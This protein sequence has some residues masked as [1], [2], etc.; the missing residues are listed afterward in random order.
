MTE[1]NASDK[2]ARLLQRIQSGDQA[3][4]EQLVAALYDD[5]RRIA[6]TH[7]RAERQGHTLQPTAL[8]HEAYVRV[9]ARDPSFADRTHFVATMA[10]A[11]RRILVDYARSRNG[12]RRGGRHRVQLGSEEQLSLEAAD[13]S[14]LLILDSA[15]DRL[16]LEKEE[17]ARFVEMHYFGGMTALEIAAVTGVSVH[18]VRQ[19]IRFGQ[20][21]LRRIMTSADQPPDQ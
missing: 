3:A 10:L 1:D 9:F 7:L 11:M 13:V 12:P 18:M 19:R 8:L 15:L 21:W 14:G 6:Q 4:R 2:I 17:V 16:A 20:A 5:L